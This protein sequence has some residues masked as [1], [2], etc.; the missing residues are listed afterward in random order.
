MSDRV[1][2]VAIDAWQG[3][4][5]VVVYDNLRDMGLCA[6]PSVVAHAPAVNFL[7]TECRGNLYV[8]LPADRL[9]ALQIPE[10]ARTEGGP[11]RQYVPVD[12]RA[13]TTTGISAEDR[14]ATIRALIDPSSRP[15]DFIQPGHLTPMAAQDGGVLARLGLAEALQGLSRMAGCGDS[16]TV[17]A[18]LDQ[19]GELGDRAELESF[20]ARH[21]TPL[22]SI[23]D[24][25]RSERRLRGWATAGTDEI[26]KD[27][28][29]PLQG[30]RVVVR[31]RGVHVVRPTLP[32]KVHGLCVPHH[33]LRAEGECVGGL[34]Q[35]LDALAAAACGAVVV[36]WSPTDPSPTCSAEPIQFEDGLTDVIAAD[37]VAGVPTTAW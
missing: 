37:L 18:V 34:A 35:D 8:I 32:V 9:R 28:Q 20:A 24:V 36:W 5:P 11:Y 1:V 7:V 27:L 3:S 31:A 16:V 30:L 26:I 29:V 22:L 10:H 23:A 33:V 4:R 13:G 25:V 14:A 6:I 19:A 15:T 17:A 2:E 12:V 21:G